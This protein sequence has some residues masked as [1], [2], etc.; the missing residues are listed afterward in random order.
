MERTMSDYSLGIP[1]I[2]EKINGVPKGANLMMLGPPLTGKHLLV[3][4]IICHTIKNGNTAI[5]VSTRDPGEDITEW[6]SQYL[7]KEELTHMGIVDCVT[8]S[9]G[10]SAQDTE[11]IKYA[12]SPVDLTGIGVKIS[13]FFEQF[14]RKKQIQ[15][16]VLCIDSVS[17]ILMYTNIQTLFRFLHVFSGRVKIAGGI[18]LYI[19]DEG[20]HSEKDINTLKQL[21]S[22]LIEIKTENEENHLRVTGLTPKPTPWLKYEINGVEVTTE[23]TNNGE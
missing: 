6:F 19:V 5:L 18:G 8:K 4:H 11:N 20:M 14:I 21:F 22:G 9:L 3:R 12:S 13:Q 23:E 7:N 1:K 16:T 15:K 17:T 2:D 10:K